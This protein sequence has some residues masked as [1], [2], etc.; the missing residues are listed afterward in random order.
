METKE[1]KTPLKIEVPQQNPE[2]AVAV[3]FMDKVPA[4]WTIVESEVGVYCVNSNSRETFT[5]TLEEFN[6]LLKG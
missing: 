2:Q 4:H 6:K 5:G 3:V 1:I